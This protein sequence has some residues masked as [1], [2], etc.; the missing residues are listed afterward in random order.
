MG[1]KGSGKT[2]SGND[3][4]SDTKNPNNPAHKSAHDN[5]SN[6]MNPNHSPTKGPGGASPANNPPGGGGRPGSDSS[7][8]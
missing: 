6:Q 7:K 2:P 1:N 4:R 3:S 5:R 8:H